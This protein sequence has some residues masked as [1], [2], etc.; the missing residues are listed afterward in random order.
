MHRE[1]AE[2]DWSPDGQLILFT[3]AWGPS[4]NRE[5]QLRTVR[6]DGRENRFLIGLEQSYSPAWSPHGTRIAYWKDGTVVVDTAAALAGDAEGVRPYPAFTG[7]CD[8]HPAL[9][10]TA[11]CGPA[12]WSPDGQHLYA[13]DIAGRSVL[14]LS[15]DGSEPP[16]EIPLTSTSPTDAIAAWQPVRD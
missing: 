3:H 10:G 7:A 8:E 15:P 9:A 14:V 2:S 6:P 11:F 16:I 12:G 5:Q 4:W 1:E 13:R